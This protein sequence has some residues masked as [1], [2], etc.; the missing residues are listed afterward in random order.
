M[1]INCDFELKM[2]GSVYT[3]VGR[4]CLQGNSTLIIL[5]QIALDKRC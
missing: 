5:L 1:W 3:T 2:D 4:S